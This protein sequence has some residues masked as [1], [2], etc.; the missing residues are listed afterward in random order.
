MRQEGEGEGG[1]EGGRGSESEC[2]RA[3]TGDIV[4]LTP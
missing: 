3:G 1:M 2:L 4:T